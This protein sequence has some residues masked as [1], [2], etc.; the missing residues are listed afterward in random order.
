MPSFGA[1]TVFPT[2]RSTSREGTHGNERC[3]PMSMAWC[4]GGLADVK[5]A[6]L[7]CC[8]EVPCEGRKSCRNGGV[9]AVRILENRDPPGVGD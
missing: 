9:N 2:S 3:E 6:V 1:S 4:V 8:L 7:D 5:V